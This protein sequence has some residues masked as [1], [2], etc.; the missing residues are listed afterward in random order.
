ME[1]TQPTFAHFL[2]LIILSLA[3]GIQSVLLAKDKGR[4]IVL[5]GLLGFIPVVNFF[6][7]WYFVGASNLRHERQLTD[8]LQRLGK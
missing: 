3:L 8:I 5:W 2:P 1:T 6:C 4:N 7:F